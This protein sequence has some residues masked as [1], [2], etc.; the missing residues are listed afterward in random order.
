MEIFLI[1]HTTP[2]VAKGI[3]YGQ[4]DLDVTE[5]FTEEASAILGHLPTNITKVYSSPLQ[6]CAKLANILFPD[7][8]IEW[9]N[10]LM[11]LNCGEWEMLEWDTIP[12]AEIQPWMD[13][14][15]HVPVPG[16]ESYA[17]LHQRVVDRFNAI[18]NNRETSAIVA[19][20]GVLR[21]ILSHIGSISLESSFSVFQLHYGAVVKIKLDNEAFTYELLHNIEPSNKE[22]HRPSFT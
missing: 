16:G 10:D 11:E 4:T 13:N 1:R 12:K 6:R 2:L 18:C 22:Q 9:H 17:Q 5:S 21:S 3:C 8:G 14:F 20:G 7:H 15:V 19:H